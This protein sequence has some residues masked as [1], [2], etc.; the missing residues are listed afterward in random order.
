MDAN[1][2]IRSASAAASLS[3]QVVT[4]LVSR[5]TDEKAFR[6]FKE[7]LAEIPTFP[8]R[9]QEQAYATLFEQAM[10]QLTEGEMQTSRS[11][12]TALQKQFQNVKP[13]GVLMLL[14]EDKQ[15]VFMLVADLFNRL[16]REIQP[17]IGGGLFERIFHLIAE[18]TMFEPVKFGKTID[19]GEVRISNTEE[20]LELTHRLLS[21]LYERM[22][23]IVGTDAAKEILERHFREL[24]R[25]HSFLPVIFDL[26]AAMPDGVLGEERRERLSHLEQV[27]DKKAKDLSVVN[28]R[29]TDQTD[30]LIRTVDELSEAN[31]RLKSLDVARRDFIRVV[32]HQFRTPLSAIRWNVD[33]LKSELKKYK[34]DPKDI[35]VVEA[36]EAE[37]KFLISALKKVFYALEIDTEAIVYDRKPAFLWEIVK[38]VIDESQEEAGKRGLEIRFEKA[39]KALVQI[40]LDSEKM[41]EVIRILLSNAVAYS[42]E[43]GI[44][45]VRLDTIELDGDSYTHLQIKDGGIGMKKDDLKRVFDKFFRGENAVKNVQNGT[46]LGMYVVKHVVEAH[47]GTV[48]I[49]SALN[50]GTTVDV[51]LPQLTQT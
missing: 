17:I 12:Q 4:F 25:R 14:Y 19:W 10:R 11:V 15:Q 27:I 35:E 39:E 21:D 7:K 2:N 31:E 38:D 50:D 43:K 24:Y 23:W 3:A 16:Y 42:Q 47:G 26:L 28:E 6:R 49:A 37:N 34:V 8:E 1:G 29:L 32:S 40:P 5:V 18:G 51:N 48:A 45:D 9:K 41:T 36:I 13:E 46:G 22:A 30:E 44:V 20:C 33:L